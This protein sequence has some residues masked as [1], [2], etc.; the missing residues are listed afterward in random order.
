MIPTFTRDFM[1]FVSQF[2]SDVTFMADSELNIRPGVRLIQ[3]AFRTNYL[4]TG[5]KYQLTRVL[6]FSVAR[7]MRLRQGG[8]SPF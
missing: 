5:V 2:C 4:R 1:T 3:R 6:S 8:S 7:G